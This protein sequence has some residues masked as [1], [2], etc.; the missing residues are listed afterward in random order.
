MPGLGRAQRSGRPE[1]RSGPYPI[2]FGAVAQMG[3]RCNRTAEVRGSIPL[4]STSH[5]TLDR[6]S[7]ARSDNV[8]HF[9]ALGGRCV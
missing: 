7:Y 3:E 6:H 1:R 5:S 4:G 8:R 2:R 9:R